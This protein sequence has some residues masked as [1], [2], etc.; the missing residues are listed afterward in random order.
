MPPLRTRRTPWA[1]GCAVVALTTALSLTAPTRAWAEP[2]TLAEALARASAT[3]PTLI[4][5]QAEVRAAEGRALQA[6]LRPNPELDLSI[7]NFAGTGAFRGLEET[8]STLSIGQRFELGGKRTA[9][10][11]AA[12]AEI[13]AARLGF[14]VARAD[15]MTEVRNAYAEAYADGRRLDL[16]REQF[17]RAEN[18]QAIATEL[19]DA[20][21]EPPLRALRARTAALEAVGRVRAAEAEYAQAQRALAALWGDTETLPEPLPPLSEPAPTIGAAPA[22]TL[23]VRLAEAEV[24]ASVAAFERERTLSRPD[25]TVSVGARQ[26]RGT[27]DTAV[28]FG[29]SVPIGV[30]DRNQGNIAAANADRIGAEA[31]RNAA[32]AAAV[33]RTRDAQAA[34]R[35]A[36]ARLSFLETRAEPEAVE[37]VRIAREGFAAGRFT[38][39]DVLDAEEALNTLQSDMITAELDRSQAFAALTRATETQGSTQ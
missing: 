18:L 27:D 23:D 21:R 5:A 39:L 3:C 8:E 11:R 30:F 24:A 17:V 37:A 29:A 34:L 22:A 12:E 13:E 1:F 36:E 9:R 7:E 4:A 28:V 35:T 38:L 2:L 15:L 14:A 19:V 10:Q 32:L 26:F 25:V 31:R 6:G 16:A 20:G 33:R